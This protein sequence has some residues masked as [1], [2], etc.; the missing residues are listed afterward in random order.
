MML[1]GLEILLDRMKTNPE[2]FLKDGNVPYDG[3]TFGGKWADLLDYAWRVGDD[4]ERKAL[5]DAKIAFYRDDFNERVMKR[6]AGEETTQEQLSPYI[7]KQ[8]HWTDPRAK[9]TTAISSGWTDPKGIYGSQ[10][11]LQNSMLSGNGSTNV[12]GVVQGGY[13][14]A[15][16]RQEGAAIGVDPSFWGGIIASGKG[17][18]W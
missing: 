15:Q 5:Q 13:G 3:E 2:E 12:Q 18:L 10:A 11:A 14:Q 1:T 8:Q 4:E 17:K 6:L 16:V 9:T 7:V